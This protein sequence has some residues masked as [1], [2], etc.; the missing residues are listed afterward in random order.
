MSDNVQHPKHYEGHTSLECI[1][2]MEL[3]FGT[4]NTAMFCLEN[5]FKYL[6]RHENKNAEEDVDKAGWY[7]NWVEHKRDL[8]KDSNE[9]L[10]IEVVEKIPL[11]RN[12]YKKAKARYSA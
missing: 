8:L 7:L 12:L 1:D 5:A 9:V 4:D 11:L 3:I 6:W 10:S 2:C